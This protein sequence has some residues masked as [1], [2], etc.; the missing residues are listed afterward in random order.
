[1]NDI[2]EKIKSIRKSRGLTQKQLGEK[3]GI[4][5]ALVGQYETGKRKPKLEQITRIANALSVDIGDLID[6]VP[7]NNYMSIEQFLD[8]VKYLVGESNAKSPFDPYVVSDFLDG[9]ELS[10]EEMV[11]VTKFTD[12]LDR[13]KDK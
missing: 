6:S 2:G 4:S 7:I 11:E 5:Q 1:M 13:S 10:D 12:F 9:K 8:M 3:L